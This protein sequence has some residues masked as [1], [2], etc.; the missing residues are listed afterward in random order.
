MSP[1]TSYTQGRAHGPGAFRAGLDASHGYRAGP[2]CMCTAMELQDVVHGIAVVCTNG[3]IDV[4]DDSCPSGEIHDTI[5][6]VRLALKY[7]EASG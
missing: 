3:A 4:L 1:R 5:P 6:D 7:R 2:L